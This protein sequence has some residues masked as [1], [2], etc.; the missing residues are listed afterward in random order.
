MLVQSCLLS[1]LLFVASATAHAYPPA[2]L[3]PRYLVTGTGISLPSSSASPYP[4]ATANGTGT[5]TGSVSTSTPTS[6]PIPPSEFFY[7][8]IADTGTAHDGQ[9]LSIDSDTNGDSSLVLYPAAE[10]NEVAS[11]ST[12][13]INADGTLENEFAGI[14]AIFPEGTSQSL[15]FEN[16]VYVDESG[17]I[18]STCEVVG[19]I[20]TCQS[21]A[22]TV[23]FICPYQVISGTLIGG[24][25]EVGPN[26]QSGCTPITLLV[27][28]V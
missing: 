22:D 12:F 14:A 24:S 6:N 21:G 18:K 16:E 28:P 9:Y 26:T 23:F 7:L 8:V 13:N 10:P 17:D 20:L 25:V 2:G 15:F 19:G 1:S 4:T 5:P 3:R 11:F 27:V